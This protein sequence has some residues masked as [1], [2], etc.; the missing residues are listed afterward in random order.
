MLSLLRLLPLSLAALAVANLV[1]VGEATGSRA[2]PSED[3]DY[4]VQIQ[5]VLDPISGDL[6]AA[7][8]NEEEGNE[9]LGLLSLFGTE[10]G[11]ARAND[12]GSHEVPVVI[13]KAIDRTKSVLNRTKSVLNLLGSQG[14]TRNRSRFNL[15]NFSSFAGKLDEGFDPLAVDEDSA[16]HEDSVRTYDNFTD[17]DNDP[18]AVH[19]LVN[20][21]DIAVL[22]SAIGLVMLSDIVALLKAQHR[23]RT[24]NFVDEE[25]ED[26]GSL[27]P[28]ISYAGCMV[29]LSAA[30]AAN[31][32]ALRSY[33]DA[34]LWAYAYGEE[35][36]LSFDNIFV[37]VFLFRTLALPTDTKQ[38]ALKYGIYGCMVVRA[39]SLTVMPPVDHPGWWAILTG[40]LMIVVAFAAI[41]DTN[42]ARDAV[43]SLRCL[44]N[45]ES[46]TQDEERKRIGAAGWDFLSASLLLV[47]ADFAFC[48]DSACFRRVMDPYVRVSSAMM[49]MATLRGI[50][51]V[52]EELLRAFR[53]LEL[54]AG[55]IMVMCGLYTICMAV[56]GFAT[57][58]FWVVTPF[59]LAVSI[60]ASILVP[61]DDQVGRLVAEIQAKAKA[62][63]H[64][65]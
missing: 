47:I 61:E 28:A 43:H 2:F 36:A 63:P 34:Q 55:G 31:M 49:V 4:M 17:A 50:F 12:T 58:M 35:L 7:G 29:L 21:R 54:G 48:L 40:T 44:R 10:F 56:G 24:R 37:F 25:Q 45:V 60:I 46:G 51:W 3:D 16:T 22:G 26:S 59:F 52:W 5:T 1:P 30:F 65:G 14:T 23:P 42:T 15:G 13:K 53:F 32:W 6:L 19:R 8:L 38:K 39:I 18:K 62:C 20:S 9:D 41:L 57:L 27:L 64:L 33:A 11:G